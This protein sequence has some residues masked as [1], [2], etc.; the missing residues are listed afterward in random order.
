[1]RLVEDGRELDEIRVVCKEDD[2]CTAD[3]VWDNRALAAGIH[4]IGVRLEDSHGNVSHAVHEVALQDVFEVTSLR[5]TNEPHRRARGH[6]HANGRLGWLG[7][8]WRRLHGGWFARLAVA[9]ARYCRVA[10]QR[11]KSFSRVLEK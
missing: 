3:G 4:Q 6:R 8:Q 11:S 2:T 1:M 9:R 7:Q 5:V 10:V